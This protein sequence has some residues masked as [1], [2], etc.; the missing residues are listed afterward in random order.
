MSGRERF[1]SRITWVHCRDWPIVGAGY[2]DDDNIA[3]LSKERIVGLSKLAR[4]SGVTVNMG[5]RQAQRL[6][7]EL[8]CVKNNPLSD[9]QTFA[10]VV[11]LL[12]DVAIRIE[13]G[14]AGNCCFPTKGPSR[15]FG[16][17]DSMSKHVADVLTDYLN[18]AT[19][20]HVG[21]ADSRFGAYV[22]AIC[23]DGGQ[24]PVVA[25]GQTRQFLAE[26]PVDLLVGAM[27]E[28]GVDMSAS[29]HKETVEIVETLKRLGLVDLGDFTRLSQAEV[30]GRFATIGSLLHDWAN[31]YDHLPTFPEEIE[32]HSC[33]AVELDPPISQVER[34]VFV[35]KSLADDFSSM[36]KR[37]GSSCG[38]I[39]IILTADSGQSQQ[40]VWRSAK[41]FDAR[42]VAERLRWQV[43]GWLSNVNKNRL[44]GALTRIELRPDD[45]GAV[46]IEQLSL[47]QSDTSELDRATR[48]IARVQAQYGPG[49]V[50]LLEVAGGRNV[51]DSVGVIPAESLD[52][53]S[54]SS[55]SAARA[56]ELRVWPNA[57]PKPEPAIKV[58]GT[59]RV[60]LLDKRGHSVTVN[61]R[62]LLS[63]EPVWLSIGQRRYEIDSY[64]P[65]WPLSERWWDKDRVKHCVRMQILTKNQRAYLL[66]QVRG[67]WYLDAVYD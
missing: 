62:S 22:A 67:L 26:L 42:M 3:V 21:T 65:P 23:A 29:C 27:R 20:V 14:T 47:W 25:P 15:Y 4:E 9:I 6:C 63:Q 1:T 45:L 7:P 57:V 28:I 24:T 10:S 43:D 56:A 53:F 5:R 46:E 60:E 34:A 40:R 33:V 2:G 50:S 38:R 37:R 41:A 32:Q 66:R 16:G 64:S 19:T 59:E 39:T 18:G 13:M 31:G 12:G 48:S 8:V 55:K 61:T 58:V 54:H 11:N 30:L 49:S 35:T 51:G 17:D 36:L 52:L 44:V